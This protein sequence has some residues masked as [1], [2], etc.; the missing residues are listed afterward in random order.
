MNFR[1]VMRRGRRVY[2]L[3]HNDN[4]RR[5]LQYLTEVQ[6]T[7]GIFKNIRITAYHGKHYNPDKFSWIVE[8]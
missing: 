5:A 4:I 6:T 3:C 2:L 7:T 8:G 1:K